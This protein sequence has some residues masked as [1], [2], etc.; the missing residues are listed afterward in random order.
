MKEEKMKKIEIYDTTLRDGGQSEDVSWSIEDKLRI[1]ER[2]DDFGVDYIEGGWPGANPKDTEF[3]TRVKKLKLKNAKMVAFGSTHRT[4]KKV[5]K[6]SN[7]KK[8][9]AANTS[10]ITIFGKTWDFHVKEAL[11][12]TNERNLELISNTVR[13]L[14]KKVQEVFFD[15]EHFFDGYKANPDYALR[16]LE[17]A[18]KAGADRIILCDTNG[19]TMPN[20]VAEI[21]K[22]VKSRIN[23]PIGIHAHN[24]GD[25]A[26]AN[27]IIAV[28]NGAIQVQGTINGLGERCGNANL[29]SVIPDLQLKLGYRCITDQQLSKLKEIS[30][31]VSEVANLRTFKRQPYVGDSA[32]AHKG[33]VHV[34]AI[35]KHPGTYEHEVPELFGNSRKILQSDQGGRANVIRKLKEF[36]LQVDP[37]DKV[38]NTI[39]KDIK[40]MENMGFVFE[41]ADASLELLM[42]YRLKKYA[43]PFEVHDYSVFV[44]KDNNKVFDIT[45]L[46][47]VNGNRKKSLEAPSRAT[48][49]I[50]T[51]TT[52]VECTAEKGNG[53]V[54]AL[55][56][57]LYK[58]LVGPYPEMKK[59]RLIDYKVRVIDT[60]KGTKAKVRVLTEFEA[61]NTK[62]STV[63]ADENVV[64]ASLYALISGIEYFLLKVRRKL[65]KK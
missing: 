53:P 43:R 1:V 48:I 15:A 56:N 6:D 59:M 34:N 20:E 11:R 21:V 39:A 24:D 63:G 23:V 38:V 26:V 42:W 37:E 61:E 36:N 29:I 13:Y 30:R 7:I 51:P 33:G 17:T 16:C 57:A 4:S 58:A 46:L 5:Y 10:V 35:L 60:V 31:F 52:S 47:R 27:S 62:W 18:E 50:R 19:G 32:F 45:E 14:K 40:Y 55:A 64:V 28:L 3:F 54:N 65:N 2:L 22:A 8:L 49:D 41:G 12:V 9:L 25:C 44:N